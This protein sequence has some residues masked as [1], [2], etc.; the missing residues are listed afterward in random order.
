MKFCSK[1]ITIQ[2]K[3]KQ[4]RIKTSKWKYHL[5][6]AEY[7]WTHSIGIFTNQMVVSWCIMLMLMLMLIIDHCEFFFV[8]SLYYILIKLVK[9]Y[10]HMA[11][12]GCVKGHDI[13]LYMTQRRYSFIVVSKIDTPF[14]NWFWFYGARYNKFQYQNGNSNGNSCICYYIN[15]SDI[16]VWQ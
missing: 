14:H 16:H 15:L 13:Y 9:F 6:L 10:M 2:N 11:W 5:C 12:V 7:Q 1:K 8:A 4:K 3:T